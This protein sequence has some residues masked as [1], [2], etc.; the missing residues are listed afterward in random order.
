[1]IDTHCHIDLYQDPSKIALQTERK[2]ITTILV[3]NLP[4]SF[5]KSYPYTRGFKYIRLALGLH[6]LM[7][8]QHYEEK[9]LFEKLVNKT[10]YIGEVG[11]DFSV[12][13]VATKNI[14]IE[15]FRFVL[16]TIKNEP[17]FISIHS[18][19]AE[20][21][22][23]DI[24]EE[25]KS[26]PVVFHWYSGSVNDLDKA[27]INGHYF[28]INPA[29]VNSNNGKKI[30]ERIPPERVLTETDGPFVKLGNRVVMPKDVSIVEN[31][32]STSWSEDRNEVSKIIK[33]NFFKLLEPIRKRV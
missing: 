14:Q 19:K 18:R 21:I 12:N 24:L 5:E 31:Y 4:S 10:S 23:L 2:K 1:M 30:I 13:R 11:L 25:E 20:S 15:S 33:N 29:M 16:K 17:K 32:L 6:P 26:G 7:A 3:T 27:I 8:E 9:K 28:S 22:I